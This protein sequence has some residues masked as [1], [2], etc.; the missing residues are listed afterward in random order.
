MPGGLSAGDETLKFTAKACGGDADD[1]EI[2]IH[3]Q[4]ATTRPS[5]AFVVDGTKEGDFDA[6]NEDHSVGTA[7]YDYLDYTRN[8]S[9]ALD[10]FDL[11]PQNVYSTVDEKAIRQHYSQFDAII[12]TD[13]P[14][15]STKIGKKSCVD[16][17]GTMIDIRPILTMEAYVSSLSNWKAKGISGNPTS[18]NPRQ[19]AMKLECK[20]HAIFNGLNPASDN[21]HVDTEGGVDYWTVTMVD[22]TKSPYAGLDDD[23]ETGGGEKPALQGFSASNVDGLLL[24]GEISE[25]TLY[26]GVE[27]QDEPAARL[28][29]LGVQYKA[30]PSALTP[31]GLIVIKNALKYLLKT[32]MEEVDDCSNYFT[33]AYG[34]HKWSTAANWSKGKAPDVTVK[35][36][37]LK[38][39]VIDGTAYAAQVDIATSGK[40][41]KFDTPADCSGKLT[42]DPT[43]ALI[44][45]GEVHSAKAPYFNTGDLKP[46]EAADLVMN[47]NGSNQSAL[48]LDNDEG[49]TKATVNMYSLGIKPISYQ[50]QY[51]AIPMEYLPVNPTFA[52]ENHGGTKIY[53]YVWEEGTS[54]WTRRKYYDDLFAFEGLGI[55]T[56][57]SESHMDYTMTGN[58]TSTAE[59]DITL[60][61]DGVGNNIIGNSYTAPISIASLVSAFEDD[62]SVTKTV[63]IYCAGRDAEKGIGASGSTETAGQWLA[64]PMEAATFKDWEG[65]TVIPAMQ[66]FLI[67]VSAETSMTLNYNDMVRSNKS[68]YNEKLRAPQRFADE[69]AATTL[70]RIRVADSKT[71][72]DLYLF[73]GEQFSEAFDNGWEAKYMSGDGRSAKLYA[74]TTVGQMAVAAQPEYEGTVLGFAPG[75]ETEYTF[76][77]TGP[78]KEYY[79]NDLKLKKSTLIS[80]G[81]SYRFTFEEGDTN[82]F[83]ISRTRID[84]P[85]VATGTENTADGAKARKVIVNDK[86]YIIRN[87]RVYSAEGII[88]K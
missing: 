74:E 62:E 11:T 6:E 79:L 27:R 40:S 2:T 5:V 26:T 73:E 69:P 43:G 87:G 46:T 44:V 22:K 39:C 66:A 34:D 29:L 83:Y 18:P 84:A 14:S 72:T 88:V 70:T 7:L 56:N 33:D 23:E 76:T 47:T 19:Y 21:V 54:S 3:K 49:D 13:D 68:N 71:H 24:L 85:A 41:S 51:F 31:E 38:P 77:F 42:I 80:E 59:R 52:N 35:A 65:L 50:Y 61:A 20:D 81:E 60:T 45:G 78:D 30:L 28:M 67:Q 63:Y 16:A 17:F 82:R 64:I 48:I 57:S 86:L 53:T 4:A 10:L 12:I 32:D 58:L 15:T 25:G 37:I 1:V 36:R 8:G 55:T 75:Q 9:G